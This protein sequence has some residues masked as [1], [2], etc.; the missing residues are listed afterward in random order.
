MG[1]LSFMRTSSEGSL[2]DSTRREGLEVNDEAKA[3]AWVKHL[4]EKGVR[5]LCLDFDLT[6]VSVHTGGKWR[7]TIEALAARVR[8]VFKI[9]IAEALS[10]G[11]E[12]CI[13]TMSRQCRLV[14]DVLHMALCFTCDVSK[15]I[16][17]G[18]ER[19]RLVTEAGE[20]DSFLYD[21]SRKQSHIKSVLAARRQ[22]GGDE[23]VASQV[24]LV[25]DD[26]F[27]V[28]EALDNGY[29]AVAFD[30][31]N[32]LTVPP[33]SE[34][35]SLF[36]PLPPPCT[37]LPSTPRSSHLLSACE[38]RSPTCLQAS[39]AVEPTFRHSPLGAF[40]SSVLSPGLNSA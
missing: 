29:R 7:G 19:G 14:A 2:A 16:I 3:L 35:C 31:D 26:A 5:L 6:L 37:P 18:G 20:P 13:V 39:A 23:L 9:V 8:P 30:P 22:R 32:P 17:R 24:L 1:G 4:E 27:N 25:D 40:G 15:I 10:C 36:Q 33:L 34:V 38:A 11:I 12:V 21:G 28:E